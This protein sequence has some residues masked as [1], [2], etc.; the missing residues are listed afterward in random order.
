MLLK[1]LCLRLNSPGIICFSFPFLDQGIRLEALKCQDVLNCDSEDDFRHFWTASLSALWLTEFKYIEEFRLFITN[2][3]IMYSRCE[4]K[5]MVQLSAFFL[6]LNQQW[7]KL[8]RYRL[9]KFYEFLK[10]YLFKMTELDSKGSKSKD[11][12]WILRDSIF[13]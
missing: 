12:F 1:E 3:L 11:S 4:E 13:K 7:S 8:D 9:N 5:F 6:S 10:I 2:V